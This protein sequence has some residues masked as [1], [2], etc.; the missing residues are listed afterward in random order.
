MDIRSDNGKH[1]IVQLWRVEGACTHH[2]HHTWQ[3]SDDP[4]GFHSIFIE[5]YL[6]ASEITIFTDVSR[7][8]QQNILYNHLISSTQNMP[9]R[10]F[11]DNYVKYA[12][13]S[14]FFFFFLV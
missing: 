11:L 9:Q 7:P 12:I 1:T 6:F 13:F 4:A 5:L 14:V 8:L 10:Y 2:S 3:A